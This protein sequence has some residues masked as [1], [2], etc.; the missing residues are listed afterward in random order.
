MNNRKRIVDH[1]P[2][3]IS[4]SLISIDTFSSLAPSLSLNGWKEEGQ[5]APCMKKEDCW[6]PSD[7][8]SSLGRNYNV[9]SGSPPLHV[10]LIF[11]PALAPL[12]L[13]FL[14]PNT[15]FPPRSFDQK[16]NK[17]SVFSLVSVL[18]PLAI[19]PTYGLVD[20]KE[21]QLR[22]SAVV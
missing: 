8:E 12:S 17:S 13:S 15:L 6:N 7:I 10:L 4:P 20:W 22:L 5:N 18:P 3:A 2:S 9:K 21:D 1:L 14:G 11:A 19:P 16:D